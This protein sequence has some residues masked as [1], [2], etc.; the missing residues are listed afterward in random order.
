MGRVIQL[1]ASPGGSLLGSYNQGSPSTAQ[2]KDAISL[3]DAISLLPVVDY[4]QKNLGGLGDK[5]ASGV[6]ALGESAVKAFTPKKYVDFTPPDEQKP[7][8]IGDYIGD[9]IPKAPSQDIEPGERWQFGHLN[10]DELAKSEDKKAKAELQRRLT[11]KEDASRLD[12]YRSGARDF[13]DAALPTP[14]ATLDDQPIPVD[15][16]KMPLDQLN[17]LRNKAFEKARSYAG[18]G[19]SG[20]GHAEKALDVA[21]AI[22]AEVARRKNPAIAGAEG[23]RGSQ[24]LPR[25]TGG[26]EHFRQGA[27]YGERAPERGMGPYVTPP[28]AQ[29]SLYKGRYG[30]QEAA[31]LDLGPTGTQ[32]PSAPSAEKYQPE[33][34][35]TPA[36]AMPEGEVQ[37][38]VV[39]LGLGE[40]PNLEELTDEDLSLAKRFA[41]YHKRVK[42]DSDAF[43]ALSAEEA[44]R[45]LGRSQ[46]APGSQE[47][48]A[49]QGIPPELQGREVADLAAKGRG[50]YGS[51]APKPASVN[52]DGTQNPAQTLKLLGGAPEANGDLTPEEWKASGGS[53]PPK[54]QGRELMD[55]T[56][57]EPGYS[58]TSTGGPAPGYE[59][60]GSPVTTDRGRARKE[61]YKSPTTGKWVYPLP[62]AYENPPPNSV[63]ATEEA[64][65][66]ARGVIKGLTAEQQ[67][68]AKGLFGM[69][70][71]DE[72][73]QAKQKLETQPLTPERKAMFQILLGEIKNRNGTDTGL[74]GE[75]AKL[76][77]GTEPVTLPK[78]LGLAMQARTGTLAEKRAVLELTRDAQLPSHGLF[79]SLGLA[80]GPQERALAQVLQVM[81]PTKTDN[82]LMDLKRMELMEK[83]TEAGSKER[84]L[85]ATAGLA[86]TRGGVL[87][88]ESPFK[89]AKL[90]AGSAQSLAA[91]ES[92]LGRL[93]R[94]LGLR[95][96]KA[97]GTGG[98]GAGYKAI[99]KEAQDQENKATAEIGKAGNAS[100]TAYTKAA[101]AA[102]VPA[103]PK[104]TGMQVYDDQQMRKW[105]SDNYE[106]LKASQAAVP[107]LAEG[108]RWEK[109]SKKWHEVQTSALKAKEKAFDIKYG[110]GAWKKSGLGSEFPESAPGGSPPPSGDSGPAF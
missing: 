18:T 55:L 40:T 66:L 99:T 20:T 26:V 58:T 27:L 24:V 51:T 33:V 48:A 15:L 36:R 104:P 49:P 22:D 89:I 100:Q 75:I 86:E 29:P 44:R 63:A 82:P 35:G 50:G 45:G 70:D 1:S 6:K 107:L 72:L 92:S 95:P 5:I 108:L 54:R 96:P 52:R 77:E 73:S 101:I 83:I 94:V 78:L 53:N 25:D 71:E 31:P 37:D 81:A 13:E 21:R 11:E 12:T 103:P 79:E 87:T 14:R 17:L 67:A 90:A 23:L 105:L 109:S 4:A 42:G 80:N 88:A 57:G 59:A 98:G 30:G 60:G 19:S 16:G 41:E 65:A 38:I 69:M 102:G 46:K 7:L 85:E 34:Q 68:K 97:G 62:H 84:K 32:A 9:N 28:K 2:T 39:R 56:P 47:P 64:T 74:V 110:E 61:P 93:T 3:H 106:K 91:A 76:K 43:D 10:N 8:G